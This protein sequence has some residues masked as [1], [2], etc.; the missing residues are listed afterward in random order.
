[1]LRVVVNS[2]PILALGNIGELDILRKMYGK[3]IIPVSVYNEVTAKQDTASKTLSVAENWIEV[4]SIENRED[5]AMYRSR[6]HSGEIEVMI[7]AQQTPRADLVIIDDMTARKTAEFLGLPLT[8]TIGVLIK[9]KQN[10][11]ISEVMPVL[12]KMENNGFFISDRIKQ[13]ISEKTGETF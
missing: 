3:I 1:M 7:L 10:G 6:L 5:Y 11:I 8:G 4:Q 12:K 9:A 2:T 13:M